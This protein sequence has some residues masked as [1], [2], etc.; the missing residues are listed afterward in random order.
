MGVSTDATSKDIKAAY[1]KL[2]RKY[3]PDV[4]KAADAEE[5]FKELGEAYEVLKDPQKRKIYDQA[6]QSGRSDDRSRWHTDP[7]AWHTGPSEGMHQTNYDFFESLFGGAPF[8]AQQGSDIHATLTITLEKAYRGTVKEF[9]L[10]DRQGK[11]HSLRVKV[12]AG[13][14]S[15]QKIRVAGHGE[16]LGP[17]GKVGDLYLTIQV[18]KHALFDVVK[19]DIYLTLPISPWEAALGA[20]VATPTLGGIVQLKIAPGSQGGQSL[21]LKGRG[22]P[23]GV[24]KGDQYVLLKI[25][26]PPATSD[27]AKSLYQKMA[28]AMPFNPRE[29]MVSYS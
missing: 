1:R 4:N 9:T 23:N 19:H 20:T 5:K 26:T 3:H 22:L 16:K 18:S 6:Q 27:Q 15:G 11:A 2:A 17:Q 28:A 10:Q 24:S 12:P 21:R 13:I 29:N 7:G 25:V 14:L 8:H